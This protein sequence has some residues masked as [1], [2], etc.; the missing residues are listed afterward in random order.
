MSSWFL[1]VW[2][3]EERSPQIR[4]IK[5]EILVRERRLNPV[6]DGTVQDFNS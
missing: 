4:F 3:G 6:G 1:A 2:H 5:S